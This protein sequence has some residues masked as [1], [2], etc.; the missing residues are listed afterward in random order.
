MCTEDISAPDPAIA[1]P[2]SADACRYIARQPILDLHGR[3]HGYE[4]LFRNDRQDF[5]GGEGELATRTMIDNSVIFGLEDLACGLPAFVNCTA[6][7]VIGRHVDLLPP[8]M[9]VIEV[10]ETADP[11]PSLVEAC[12]QL[13]ASGFRLAL[14][15][16]VWK[17]SMEPLVHLADYIKIDTKAS[18]KAQ[19]L[20]SMAHLQGRALTLVAEKVETREDYEQ[21]RAEGFT[22]FQGYYFC[23][24]VLVTKRKIPPP[25]RFLH[26][27]LLH[28]LKDDPLNLLT[29]SEL[30]KGDASLTYRL[31]R[32][33]NSPFYAI[34]QPVSSI[35]EAL[36][37]V[38]D[39]VFRRIATLAIASEFN[40]GQPAEILRMALVRARHCELASKLCALDATEQYLLGLF[41]MLPAM[42]G[43]SMEKAIDALP[44]RDEI[45]NALLGETNSERTPLEW[46]EANELG[47]WLRCDGIAR[48]R[49]VNLNHMHRCFKEAVWWTDLIFSTW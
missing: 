44:L 30:T 48:S 25:N 22:L 28:A 11:V 19:R 21:S 10:L 18:T 3:V 43:I 33:V 35:K 24:P 27:Q 46:V 23:R 26:L 49:G 37:I 45:R 15:N 9:A 31:L 8:G 1:T 42:L 17:P 36:L 14:D 32:L 41:S 2:E 39:D 7:A 20:E 29:I 5:F 13:K 4:L 38:G 6:E 12:G 40:A 34:R 47:D 16:F